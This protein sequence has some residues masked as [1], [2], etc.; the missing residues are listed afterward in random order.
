MDS[1][2]ITGIRAY[3]YTGFLPEE[4]T[5]GQWFEVNLTVWR[6]LAEPGSSDDLKDTFDYSVIVTQIQELIQTMRFQLIER[7]ADEI[8]R[9]V[10][11]SGGVTQTRVQL[12]KL[13]PPIPNFDGRVTVDISRSIEGLTD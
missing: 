6:S 13:T 2:H 4:Q 5:L 9:L 10:L 1:L 3:G 7:L 12:T 8:A 11:R